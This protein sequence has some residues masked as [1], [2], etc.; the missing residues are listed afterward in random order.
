MSAPTTFARLTGLMLATGLILGACK[1]KTVN[2]PVS[3]SSGQAGERAP[4]SGN[5]GAASAEVDYWPMIAPMVAGT[6][7]GQCQRLPDLTRSAGKIVVARDGTVS[8][9][10]FSESIANGE[11]KLSSLI[12]DGA[13]VHS[14]EAA[15]GDFKMNLA[16]RGGADGVSATM[17]RGDKVVSCDK[18]VEP[19]GMRDKRLY[20]LFAAKV[21]S[22]GQ[23]FKCYNPGALSSGEQAAL[24]FRFTDGVLHINGE[25]FD[26]KAAEQEVATFAR[27]LD[28]VE[29][30][31]ILADNVTVQFELDESGMLRRFGALAGDSK[32]Y[33]C[34][35]A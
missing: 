21:Q 2:A 29:Y 24:P 1:E 12:V 26:F 16:D 4:A 6:Y 22:P 27:G 5:T 19:T 13:P 32:M 18:V 9:G 35:P 30:R 31:G 3:P 10:D 15:D 25:A 14:M 17:V 8:A 11:I 20:P 33:M 34:E 28:R 7:T 23:D